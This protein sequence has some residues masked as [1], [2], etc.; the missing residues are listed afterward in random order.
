[1]RSMNICIVGNVGVKVKLFWRSN[2]E[3]ILTLNTKFNFK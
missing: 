1:M 3:M 2:T